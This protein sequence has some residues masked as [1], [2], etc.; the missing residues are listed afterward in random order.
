MSRFFSS[1]LSF[2]FVCVWLELGNKEKNIGNEIK[3]KIWKNYM[4]MQI[5]LI[6]TLR[7]SHDDNHQVP[8]V[9]FYCRKHTLNQHVR[10]ISLSCIV[11]RDTLSRNRCPQP[12]SKVLVRLSALQTLD[13]RT[14][15]TWALPK[16]TKYQVRSIFQ[17]A[18]PFWLHWTKFL[19][20]EVYLLYDITIKIETMVYYYY[21][22]N[23]R[24]TSRFNFC[25]FISLY[26][27]ILSNYRWHS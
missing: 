16:P 12:L 15:H 14:F 22:K 20:N 5:Y 26:F 17:I 21:G 25:Y 1:I 19:W 8:N 11:V 4:S 18:L 27:I 6:Y 13:L 23:Y 7:N 24:I 9:Y 10:P 3:R 2:S